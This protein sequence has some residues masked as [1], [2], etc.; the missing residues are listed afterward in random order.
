[1]RIGIKVERR[2]FGKN[3]YL[4]MANEPKHVV[5]YSYIYY[6]A[7]PGSKVSQ[8]YCRMWNNKELRRI[9]VASETEDNIL[10]HVLRTRVQQ[11]LKYSIN[12]MCGLY[13][14]FKC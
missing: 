6:I 13:A 2:S 4:M 1:M 10:V 7:F 14:F 9:K 3:K 11:M 12:N 8:N 5:V